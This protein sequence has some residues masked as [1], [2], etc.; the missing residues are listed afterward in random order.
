MASRSPTLWFCFPPGFAHPSCA[1]DLIFK[2]QATGEKPSGHFVN[3]LLRTEFH[4]SVVL[5]PHSLLSL[6]C[7][8]PIGDS[9]LSLSK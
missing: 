5:T 2:N 8:I 4:K 1:L 7:A 3:D 6:K 9:W